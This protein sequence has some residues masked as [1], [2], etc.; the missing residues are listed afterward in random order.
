MSQFLDRMSQSGSA[1]ETFVEY[2]RD[3]ISGQQEYLDPGRRSRPRYSSVCKV[4]QSI[5]HILPGQYWSLSAC[6]RYL[7]YKVDFTPKF[8]L[9]QLYSF[10]TFTT[11]Y[12]TLWTTYTG[13][14]TASRTTSQHFDVTHYSNLTFQSTHITFFHIITDITLYF[15][16]H[17]AGHPALSSQYILYS[18]RFL[19]IGVISRELGY[20]HVQFLVSP[21]KL[22][23]TSLFI[24]EPLPLNC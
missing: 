14:S 19:L 15:P 10:K 24:F 11:F 17:F 23:N 22:D 3:P 16:K 7:Q 13:N 8:M 20:L 18:L 4:H 12:S 9:Y 6:N 21:F 1:A 2:K 5:P